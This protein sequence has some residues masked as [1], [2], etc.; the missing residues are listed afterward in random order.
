MRLMVWFPAHPVI[1]W[2]QSVL[3]KTLTPLGQASC[4]AAQ[5]AAVGVCMCVWMSINKGVKLY[6][7]ADYLPLNLILWLGRNMDR[8]GNTAL[9]CSGNKM[10]V[11]N[12]VKKNFKRKFW[13]LKLWRN[14]LPKSNDNFLL[15]KC[16]FQFS[17]PQRLICTQTEL[18]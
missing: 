2:S 10:A 7:S 17:V 12:A 14:I 18:Q 4:M 11:L 13:H 5:P 6:I 16:Y 9:E 8:L 15:G 1:C 3:G